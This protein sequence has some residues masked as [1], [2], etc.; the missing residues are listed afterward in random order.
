MI[1]KPMQTVRKFSLLAAAL[2]AGG[3]VSIPEGPSMMALPGTGKNFDQ[4]RGDDFDCRQFAS[5]QIGGSTANEAAVNN[6]A[7]SAAIGTA[8]GA[9]AGAA[10]DGSSGAGVGAGVGLL[11]GAMVGSGTGTAS[12]YNLQQR[13]DYGYIQCMYAKGHKVP[14]SGRF[15]STAPS[16]P[17]RP[18]ASYPPP[19][20]SG[21]YPPPPPGS[22]PP[23]PPR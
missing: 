5:A 4:F 12:G 2:I 1:G 16:A 14:V 7:A 22:P 10:I 23:P 19:P 21:S 8:V 6:A 13:Y 15:T 9:L 18:S 17:A 3:C 20:S 11:G